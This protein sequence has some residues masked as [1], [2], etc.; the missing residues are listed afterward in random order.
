M[1]EAAPI[2]RPVALITGR[3]LVWSRYGLSDGLSPAVVADPFAWLTSLLVLV[4]KSYRNTSSIRL[5][6]T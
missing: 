6:S 2:R 5:T 1:S 4:A 3:L